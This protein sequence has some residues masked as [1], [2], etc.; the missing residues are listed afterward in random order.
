MDGITQ[1]WFSYMESSNLLTNWPSFANDIH[2]RFDPHDDAI[3]GGK[4]SKVTQTSTVAAYQSEYEIQA[5]K[6][7]GFPE[8]FLL[9]VF[10]SGLWDD[11]QQE[12]LKF[13]PPDIQE[14]MALA[15]TVEAQI[16]GSKFAFAGGF[17]KYSGGNPSSYKKPSQ[18]VIPRTPGLEDTQAK[19]FQSKF[20]NF[21]RLNSAER[22]ARRE[23][24]LCFNCDEKFSTGH[25]CKG[26]LF[27]L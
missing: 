7:V 23:K 12:V 20:P 24:V 17:R 4:L 14:A 13:R 16:Q 3:P 15:K 8:W 21:K 25:H 1:E 5:N 26:R 18:P 9:E 27:R 19:P 10:I 6:V 11:I 22:R 2:K